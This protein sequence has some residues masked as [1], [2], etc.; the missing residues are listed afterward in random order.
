MLN[1]DTLRS[2]HCPSCHGYEEQGGQG[3][4]LLAQGGFADPRVVIRVASV[5]AAL[6]K[7]FVVYKNGDDS[8]EEKMWTAAEGRH[9]IVEP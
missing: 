2:F 8:V 9:L 4:D 6:A 5:A 7:D 1:S 3:A